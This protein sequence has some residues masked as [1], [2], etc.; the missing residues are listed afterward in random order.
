MP[1]IQ[2]KKFTVFVC[3]TFAD[4][5]TQRQQ[6]FNLLYQLQCIP[7]GMEGF[8]PANQGQMQYIR[9]RIDECDYFI[10]IAAHRY[11][12]IAPGSTKSITEYEYNYAKDHPFDPKPIARFVIDRD[13]DWPSGPNFRSTGDDF[14]KLEAFKQQLAVGP[15]DDFFDVNRWTRDTL[16]SKVSTAIQVMLRNVERPGLVTPSLILD[17]AK[18]LGIHRLYPGL[19][20]VDKT[21]VFATGQ[22]RVRI[23]LNDGYNFLEANAKLIEGALENGTAIDI[24]LVHPDSP[25]LPAIA[26]KSVKLFEQQRGDIL[27][28]IQYIQKRFSNYP[29]LHARLH[30][31]YNTYSAFIN[32][33]FCL[34]D[35]YFNYNLKERRQDDRIGIRCDASDEDNG[36]YKKISDDFEYFWRSLDANKSA[37]VFEFSDGAQ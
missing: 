14:A 9:N 20:R 13:A 27:K 31:Q 30:K 11:G 7:I 12:T 29:G 33:T 4:L 3:S 10:V 22:K 37:D 35:F 24:L 21:D 32:D 18:K 5:Q 25:C 19:R 2:Q 26:E 36:L 8:V 1:T 17:D 6:I 34:V 23:I 28:G 16:I 15:D